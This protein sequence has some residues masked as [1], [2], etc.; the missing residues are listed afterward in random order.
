[1]INKELESF[2]YSISHDLRSPLRALIGYSQMLQEEYGD[3]VGDE[4]K[5][6]IEVIAAKAS[7]MNQ[8][9]DDLLEFSRAG[10]T[11]LQAAEVNM[12]ELVHA[13]STDLKEMLKHNATVVIGDLHPAFGD[14]ILLRQVWIN[15]LSNGVKYSSKHDKPVVEI[16]SSIVDSK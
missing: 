9:I 3:K 12:N 8:L 11:Q 4:G 7:R 15:L 1:M 2:S 5:K 14:A 6:W 10:K 16:S 13:L